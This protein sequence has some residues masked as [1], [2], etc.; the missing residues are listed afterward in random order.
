MARIILVESDNNLRRLLSLNLDIYVGADIVCKYNSDD[1]VDFLK[2]DTY[3]DLIICE[4]MIGDEK[5]ALKIS[6][7]INS[8]SLEVPI[9]LIGGDVDEELKGLPNSI[10][11]VDNS[12]WKKIIRKAAKML[13]VTAKSMTDREVPKFYPISIRSFLTMS[14][15]PVDIFTVKKG[16]KFDLVFETNSEIKQNKVRELLLKGAPYLFVYSEERVKFTEAFSDQLFEYLDK[17]NI[18][19]EDRIRATSMAFDAAQETISVV[20]MSERSVS[21]AKSTIDSISKVA[22]SSD[23]L[24]DL[25]DILFHSD[26][27]Y[28][29]K[30]SLLISI[31]AHDVIGVMGWGSEEQKRKMVFASFF[32]DI[33]IPSEQMCRIHTEPE[34]NR[35]DLSKKD[36]RAVLNHAF[37]A[38]ELLKTF[39]GAPFGADALVLEHHGAVNGIGF[40][41]YDQ[42]GR[43][44]RLA[45]VFL[46]VE[47]YVGYL[48]NTHKEFFKHNRVVEKLVQ[49]FTKDKFRKVAMALHEIVD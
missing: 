37:N 40:K 24:A 43:L 25:M 10:H 17:D 1:V 46:V 3:V 30:H 15:A 20:G 29:Y 6:Y 8:V 32:H 31:V 48:M 16:R 42:D 14:R 9:L 47:E 12:D 4:S 13:E 2:K 26:N 39:P 33:T 22:S 18:S 44:S 7:Y 36:R 23:G 11:A 28:L 21:M 41:Q 19:V 34:L 35:A 45:I 27:S 5:T 49:T 38:S